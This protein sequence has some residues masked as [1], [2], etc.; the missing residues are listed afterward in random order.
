M[1]KIMGKNGFE[2]ADNCFALANII[3]FTTQSEAITI[4][5]MVKVGKRENIF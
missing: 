1:S 3:S 2:E 5:T 4:A